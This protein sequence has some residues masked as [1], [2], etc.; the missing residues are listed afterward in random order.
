MFDLKDTRI[1][2]TPYHVLSPEERIT[3]K[4]R[5]EILAHVAKRFREEVTKH[6]DLL[7]LPTSGKQDIYKFLYI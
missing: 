5:K 6:E 3:Y 2:Q 1:S 7:N 4:E